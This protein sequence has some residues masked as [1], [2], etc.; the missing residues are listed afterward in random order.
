[1]SW[2]D[3]GRLLVALLFTPVIIGIQF[4]F[5][6]YAL[7]TFAKTAAILSIKLSVI[8]LVLTVIL[9]IFVL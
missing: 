9:F 6:C 3:I 8:G 5:H 7:V 4:V 1:M 2:R